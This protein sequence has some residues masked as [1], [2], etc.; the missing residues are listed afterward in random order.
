[1]E[2]IQAT[3]KEIDSVFELVQDTI[4]TIY[5]KYYPMEVVDFFCELH[6]KDNIAKDIE[7]G[8]VSILLDD[9]QMVGTGC[10]K[11]NHITRVYVK[12]EYQGRGYGSFIMQCLEADIA[13]YYDSVEL[14]AS[15]PASHLYEKRGYK[16]IKHNRWN[17]EIGVVLVYEI[18][19]KALVDTDTDICYEGRCFI[20]KANT[21]N[22][23][24]D[25][26][27]VFEYHQKGKIL[28]ADYSGG[29]VI[30]GHLIGSVALNGEL[31]FY[32]H[33]INIQN[34]LRVGKCHSIPRILE[35]GKLELAEKWQWLNGDK[36]EGESLIIE[37]L[38]D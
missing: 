11:E 15:L 25:G 17:V 32:Y 7:D 14:D 37:A 34:Q 22:G 21:E 4:K 1:M 29:D 13:K 3:K 31:D 18:M 19:E 26:R 2:Y 38:F 5:P 12:P 33:H 24:V 28:W 27:T 35:N 9:G 8:R 36:S 16:T 23:E 6:C 30:K 10:Y 20:P